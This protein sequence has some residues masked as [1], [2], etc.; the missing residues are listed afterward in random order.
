MNNRHEETLL[1]LGGTHDGERITIEMGAQFH[2]IPRQVQLTCKV[3]VDNSAMSQKANF[4]TYLRE[5]FYGGNATI[6]VMVLDG[7]VAE[8]MMRM[9]IEGYKKGV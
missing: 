6:P 5:S 2:R 9:L 7:L 1:F 8:D 3:G 4:E